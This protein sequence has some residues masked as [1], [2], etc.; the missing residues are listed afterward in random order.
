MLLRERS[1]VSEDPAQ[2]PSSRGYPPAAPPKPT[3][4]GGQDSPPKP[5]AMLQKSAAFCQKHGRQADRPHAGMRHAGKAQALAWLC[6][7]AVRSYGR[8]ETARS[9]LPGPS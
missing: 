8:S 7:D 9:I 1:A 5:A 4:L 3:G 2:S 6:R